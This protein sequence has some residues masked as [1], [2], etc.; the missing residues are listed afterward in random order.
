MRK[1]GHPNMA[2]RPVLSPTPVT[3]LPQ[4]S[5]TSD[6][7]I[8]DDSEEEESGSHDD[9]A[10]SIICHNLPIVWSQYQCLSIVPGKVF[11]T[12]T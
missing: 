4:I 5:L 2:N 3:G 9:S 8:E 10:V 6:L 12:I 11:E 7:D 1:M